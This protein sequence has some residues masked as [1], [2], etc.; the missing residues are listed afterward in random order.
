MN[1]IV[2]G[3]KYYGSYAGGSKHGNVTYINNTISM[4]NYTGSSS[5]RE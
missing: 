3:G 1:N 4:T 5:G 2:S